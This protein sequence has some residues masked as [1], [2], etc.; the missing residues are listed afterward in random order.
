MYKS[1]IYSK[2]LREAPPLIDSKKVREQYAIKMQM[3]SREVSAK[4]HPRVDE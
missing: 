2:S 4:Y 1:K 3:Y